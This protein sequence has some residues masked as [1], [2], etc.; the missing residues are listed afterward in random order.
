MKTFCCLA[1]YNINCYN[2]LSVAE[3]K[4]EK[5]KNPKKLGLSLCIHNVFT[6]LLHSYSQVLYTRCIHI[7]F[8]KMK[9]EVPSTNTLL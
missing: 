2:R 6:S 7:I 3:Y 8:L 5:R 1:V 4:N 9:T